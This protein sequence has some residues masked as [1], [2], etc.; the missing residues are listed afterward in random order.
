MSVLAENI[1]VLW[2]H[3][4][5]GI[6]PF[7]IENVIYMKIADQPPLEPFIRSS[8]PENWPKAEFKDPEFV[9]PFLTHCCA[10]FEITKAGVEFLSDHDSYLDEAKQSYIRKVAQ[11]NF[12]AALGIP[13]QLVGTG[14]H[15]GFILG[16]GMSAFEFERNILPLASELQSLCLITDSRIRGIEAQKDKASNKQPL[17]PREYETILYIA[18]GMR[19]KEVAHTMGISEASV[20]LYLRNARMKLG[21]RTKEEAVAKFTAVDERN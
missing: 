10:T 3:L 9:E 21:A 2:R 20:R 4:L 12:R 15:G 5:S 13:C 7:G 16:N 18:K 1:D 14:R 19:P 11:F 17:S 8:L 6:Q